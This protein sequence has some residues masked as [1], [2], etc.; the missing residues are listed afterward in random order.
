MLTMMI[1]GFAALREPARLEEFSHAFE[2]RSIENGA[3]LSKAIDDAIAED[4]SKAGG[5]E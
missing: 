4:E 2:G 1:M 3:R 5:Q